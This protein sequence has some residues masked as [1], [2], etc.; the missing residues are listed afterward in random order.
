MD[1]RKNAEAHP[2]ADAPARGLGRMAVAGGCGHEPEEHD[3]SVFNCLGLNAA[4][5]SARWMGHAAFADACART[6]RWP[7]ANTAYRAKKCAGQGIARHRSPRQRGGQSRQAPVPPPRRDRRRKE[8]G[9][10]Y[11]GTTPDKPATCPA[12]RYIGRLRPRRLLVVNPDRQDDAESQDRRAMVADQ[13]TQR[14]ATT[15]SQVCRTSLARSGQLPTTILGRLWLLP[16]E[17]PRPD[18]GAGAEPQRETIIAPK[19]EGATPP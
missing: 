10:Q 9:Q 13:L 4:A 3:V 19:A 7:R 15:E 8:T 16:G 6:A 11:G 12:R 2:D 5:R 17:P 14:R 18:K 1:A